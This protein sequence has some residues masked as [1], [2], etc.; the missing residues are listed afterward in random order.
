[1][2]DISRLDSLPDEL[3][4][5]VACILL[6]D[7][8]PSLLQMSQ[9][10]RSIAAKVVR[11]TH[12]A[13]LRHLVCMWDTTAT[14]SLQVSGDQLTSKGH[15]HGWGVAGRLPITGC[16]SWTLSCDA[17]VG[18]SLSW[19]KYINLGICD[20]STYLGLAQNINL[21]IC[22]DTAS[23]AWIISSGGTLA[24]LKYRDDGKVQYLPTPPV[25]Y[26]DLRTWDA[27]GG[28]FTG[29]QVF[30]RSKMLRLITVDVDRAEYNVSFTYDADAGTL[31]AM[32][33]GNICKL[34]SGFP[35]NVAM[36]P[37]ATMLGSRKFGAKAHLPLYVRREESPSI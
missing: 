7:H 26:P 13:A 14:H 37:F 17:S 35:P 1:M 36:R 11:Q 9:A 22:D 10:S 8:L 28:R 27:A 4:E 6:D 18:P 5:L 16:W 30:T 34:I 32:M 25:G 29:T 15:L 12:H 31:Y 20:D 21:G 3:V 2:T 19:A 23:H 24:Q 33:E